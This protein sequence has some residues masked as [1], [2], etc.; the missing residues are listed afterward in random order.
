MTS[1]QWEAL[2]LACLQEINLR[3]VDLNQDW[4]AKLKPIN[5]YPVKPQGLFQTNPTCPH[6]LLLDQNLPPLDPQ[7][8]LAVLEVLDYLD[9]HLSIQFSVEVDLDEVLLTDLSQSLT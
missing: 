8:T 6:S 4:L 5:S 1:N 9:T 3:E 2:P 7:E